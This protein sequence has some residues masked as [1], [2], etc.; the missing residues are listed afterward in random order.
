MTKRQTLIERYEANRGFKMTLKEMSIILGIPLNFLRL[1]KKIKESDPIIYDPHILLSNSSITETAED[2]TVIGNLFVTG[3]FGNYN[4]SIV[5]D[6]DSKFILSGSSLMKNGL[7]DFETK[8]THAVTIRANNGD[9]SIVDQ[10]FTI[11]VL[12]SLEGNLGPTN[13]TFV[14]FKA[15]GTL[16]AAVTGLDT[17]ASETLVSMEPDDG[18]LAISGNSIVKGSFDSPPGVYDLVI[19]TSTGRQ[20]V[21]RITVI[22]QQMTLSNDVIPENLPIGFEVGTLNIQNGNGNYAYT[23][24]SD[25]DNKFVTDEN[26]L[27]LSSSVD[28]ET[29]TSHNVTIQAD[30]GIDDPISVGFSIT[31]TNVLEG[32]LAPTM[33][34]FDVSDVPGTGIATVTGLD[35]GAQEVIVDITPDD[36]RLVLTNGNLVIKGE[37]A[38]NPGVINATVTTSAGRTLD[39]A[40][41][42][43]Q[44]TVEEGSVL[45]LSDGSTFGLSGDQVEFDLGIN[46]GADLTIRDIPIATTPSPNALILIRTPSGSRKITLSELLGTLEN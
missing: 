3:G 13:A 35:A 10:A 7:M 25:P 22:A 18:S 46:Y 24:M 36:G 16:V 5:S 44:E 41:V 31:V 26:K 28:F 17:G 34:T 20:L 1:G 2:G 38:S 6:P 30:N 9:G 32:T 12:N 27:I 42:V 40:I 29:K 4:F 8:T 23:V 15:T 33:A 43:T 45:L 19:Q 39:I 11:T 14:E 37:T 21:M